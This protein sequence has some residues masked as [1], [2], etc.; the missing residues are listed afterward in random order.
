MENTSNLPPQRKGNDVPVQEK[1]R[2]EIVDILRGF[3]V[4]GILV[5]NMA[6]YSGMEGGYQALQGTLDRAIFLL[7]R[8]LIEAKFYSLFS[9]L[10]GWGMALQMVRAGEKQRAF[11]SRYIRRL[12]ILLVFG[13]IHG[14]LIWNGDILTAYA[15]LGFLLLLFRNR[16]SRFIFVSIFLFLSLRI[17]L[18][19]PGE[20]MDSFRA[21]YSEMTHFMRLNRYSTSAY[22]DGSYWEVTQIRVQGF[23]D[24]LSYLFFPLGNVFS[25]FLLGLYAGKRKF[26]RNL[27]SFLPRI[28]LWI[29]AFFI[30]GV[31][32]NGI[33]MLSIP[34][35]N[36]IP[37]AFSVL[38]P[39]GARTIGAPA[40]MLFYVTGLIFL[41]QKDRWKERLAPLAKVGRMALTNY[42]LQSVIGT[43]IFYSYGLG[44]YGSSNPT[45]GLILTV[46]IYLGQI[47]FSAWWLERYQYGPLEWIWRTL[48]YGRRQPF[49]VG[50]THEDIR[51]RPLGSIGARLDR[52]HPLAR[53][54]IVWSLLTLW[55][56]AL[57]IWNNSSSS[58]GSRA[59]Q[60]VEI[61]QQ[62]VTDAGPPSEEQTLVEE[63]PTPFATP[64]V[65]PVVYNPGPI[66]RSGDLVALA[67]TFN[68]TRAFAEIVALT[69][70]PRLGRLAGSP[71][72]QEAGDYIARKFLNYG[73][74]PAGPDGFFQSFPVPYSPLI[75]VPTLSITGP[76]GEIFSFSAHQDFMTI[77]S[78]YAGSGNAEGT[79]L[80][81]N[82]CSFEDFTDVEAVGKIVF[83]RRISGVN[84]VRNALEHGAVGLLL[85]SE[86]PTLMDV[87]FP[88]REALVPEP[89]PTFRISPSVSQA[90]LQGS[91][92]SMS[93]LTLT[94][95]PQ[96]LETEV[97][98]TV[99]N[100]DQNACAQQT[101][102]GRNVL[103]VLPGRDPEYAHEVVIV[104]AHYDHMG[105]SPDGTTWVGANDNASGVAV[106]LEIARSWHFQ[107]FLPR[108]TVLFAA[109]DGEEVG[110]LG[111]RHYV[112]NPSY[113]LENTV[114][115]LA[116]D[117][118]GA[119]EDPLTIDGAGEFVEQ[120]QAAAD[121]YEIETA[122]SNRGR[123]DHGPFLDAGIPA[124]MLIWSGGNGS[125]PH[126]HRPLDTPEVIELE[127]LGRSGNV[128]S[129]SLLAYSE[130]EPAIH[131]LVKVRSQTAAEA[132][133]QSFLQTS[134][135]N[136]MNLDETWFNDVQS[137]EPELIELEAQD[138]L[139]RG[140]SAAANVRLKLEFRTSDE[141]EEIK[142]LTGYMGTQFTHS[143]SG[144]L[145]DGP[146]LK[147]DDPQPS[148]DPDAT[149]EESSLIVALPAGSDLDLSELR[150]RAIDIYDRAASQLGLP[151]FSGATLQLFPSSL[152]MRLSTM[153]SF[154]YE[155]DAWIEAGMIRLV[156][157]DSLPDSD[158]FSTSFIQLLMADQG[159]VAD[160]AP[161]LWNGLPAIIQADEAS[162]DFQRSMILALQR[163]LTNGEEIADDIAAWAAAE[164]LREELG[165]HGLGKIIRDLGQICQ[166]SGCEGVTT[167]DSVLLRH[168]GMTSA[169]LET[170]WRRY[171]L[172]RL[173]ETQQAIDQVLAE[174]ARAVAGADEGAYLNLVDPDIANLLTEQQH[175]FTSLTQ[176][177]AVIS[178]WHAEPIAFLDG[179]KILAMVSITVEWNADEG[180]AQQATF[181]REVHF[182]PT[183]SGYRWAGALLERRRGAHVQLFYPASDE[184]LAQELLPIFEEV[185]GQISESLGI[186]PPGQRVLKLYTSE[187]AFLSSTSIELQHGEDVEAWTEKGGSIKI[188]IQSGD[189]ADQ[190]RPQ[191]AEQII[192][193]VLLNYGIEEEWL[194]KGM[195]YYLHPSLD[196]LARQRYAT[197]YLPRLPGRIDHQALIALQDQV[198]G[199]LLD[200]E[201]S[202][203][204]AA[205]TWDAVRY[206][207][208]SYGFG[209][210]L[211]L[212]ER[213]SLGHPIEN[214]MRQVIGID[215]EVFEREWEESFLR[216]HTPERLVQIA[217][218]FD[219]NRAYRR[220]EY[221]A[222]EELK[223][224][225]AGSPEARIA[226]E[227]IAQSFELYGLKPFVEEP[228][229]NPDELDE[230]YTN[231]E[232]QPEVESQEDEYP[233]YFQHFPIHYTTFARAPFVEIL[234]NH[235]QSVE[236]F[237]YRQEI[238]A[239]PLDYPYEGPIEGQLVWVRT[240]DYGN[241]DFE[242]K[243]VIRRVTH[244]IENEITKAVD[245][246]A[247]GLILVSDREGDRGFLPKKPI[248]LE[249]LLP[250]PIPIIEL[251]VEGFN[252]FLSLIGETRVSIE[253]TPPALPLELSARIDLPINTMQSTESANVLGFIPGSDPILKDELI[254]LGAHYDHVGDDP[255]LWICPPDVS[256][257]EGP[258]D[259]ARCEV[260][261][262]FRYLG[263]NDDASGV[264]L[265]LEIARLWALQ[266][267]RPKRSVLFA[268]WG[269]QEAG[270]YGSRFYIDHPLYP[271]DQT[272]AVIQL[273][274]VGGGGGYYLVI[275]STI[276]RDGLLVYSVMSTEDLID[277]RLS[278]SLVPERE[279]SEQ[280][281]DRFSFFSPMDEFSD[282][283]DHSPFRK[284]GLSAML[285]HWRQ[286]SELNWPESHADVVEP[287][288]LGVSGRT[289]ALLLMNLAR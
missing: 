97:R 218:A 56:G 64:N 247:L 106:M 241:M 17:I 231:V 103:G 282:L 187:S 211:A 15:L 263:A 69:D 177:Q 278:L 116:L 41:N 124:G 249:P 148:D 181:R 98:M 255:D 173:T 207:V 150:G 178:S 188:L 240:E 27:E 100:A 40:M 76:N 289:V 94:Y 162:I 169:E 2:I 50:E 113:P 250:S 108:R 22:I 184:D 210:L 199:Y 225:Q 228:A 134:S 174:R 12:T 120:L 277:G 286:A 87:A 133:L 39:V 157:T 10:F 279:S 172:N 243:I 202:A 154:P 114:A 107:G 237:R 65:R 33:F 77:A 268:A 227:Y 92:I 54:A 130:G 74:Q 200:H 112:E 20:T 246:H 62:Q 192:R 43:L 222:S 141:V 238:M 36:R 52:L 79:V 276:D 111:S 221:L 71:E 31:I 196:R 89:I 139:I 226:A 170:A 287:Y 18:S 66:A 223:G 60:I 138:I 72:G 254:I 105:Q 126:Y 285:L 58:A 275:N 84:A 283:S 235:G 61:L 197:R 99:S 102:M 143:A 45:T 129:L 83:C 95:L 16:S 25:M 125:V 203:Q 96:D 205:H 5:A 233:S 236:M 266:D 88:R 206:F 140:N 244:T 182:T 49:K 160:A 121:Y 13:L 165:Y 136:L 7:T 118:V 80:W 258:A 128:A 123:S 146:N 144:W 208:D 239:M 159:V 110:L 42:I 145:C 260:E 264:A 201:R 26:F 117:M 11:L 265:L 51:T 219:E 131:D 193:N 4:F 152:T 163:A 23:L 127:D 30:I 137:L 180:S 73:L 37:D 53:L 168:L 68:M 19:L 147:I 269:V 46:M 132:D 85:Y 251:G 274:G 213:L 29:M 257:P 151:E 93:E 217:D 288:R 242:G 271:L 90:L 48:S 1:E 70:R 156:F 59:R 204:E 248:P 158:A 67:D 24:G 281:E 55:A 280:P 63:E 104:G 273:D 252:R 245:N 183:P 81:A 186:T 161:W 9:F 91:D 122:I 229:L 284:H 198:E 194:I 179:R 21:W 166:E 155:E 35:Q 190:L 164:Y 191:L 32:F 272:F 267:Y 8:L 232:G 34:F 47:R 261:P 115:V 57:V 6:V 82:N 209:D 215:L 167:I 230:I 216:G 262:G 135:T 185:A 38:I 259:P 253:E 256:W 195:S 28:K 153:P 270:E 142:S 171:W 175:W 224:R 214:A 176:N 119:G 44:F 109:W 75:E 78:G 212:L 86:S 101:C 189:Q 149:L 234:G 220:V 14:M 3:A